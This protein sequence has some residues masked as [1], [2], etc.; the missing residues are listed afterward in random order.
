[1]VFLFLFNRLFMAKNIFRETPRHALSDEVW[2]RVAPLMDALAGRRGRPPKDNRQFLHAVLWMAKTG[3][4]WR[5]LPPS[6]GFWRSVHSRFLTQAKKGGWRDL[7][8]VLADAEAVGLVCVASLSL[9]AAPCAS[10]ARKR[11]KNPEISQ[12]LQALGKSVGGLTSKFH[13]AV[14]DCGHLLGGVLTPGQA[15][16]NA[17]GA[18]LCRMVAALAPKA[19]CGDKAYG[20]KAIREQIHKIGA[21]CVIPSKNNQ[22]VQIPHDKTQYKKRNRVERYFGRLKNWRRIC[23]RTDKLAVAFASW[24]WLV[25]ALDWLSPASYD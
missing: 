14:S 3:A 2:L 19:I 6:L 8:C 22:K 15:S 9:K 10:G 12:K 24:I 5:D 7:L 13:A 17:L 1:M 18:R 21:E 20:S 4:P 25:S 16:D 23:L 11:G